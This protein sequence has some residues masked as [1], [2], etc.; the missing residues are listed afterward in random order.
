[1]EFMKITKR[2]KKLLIVVGILLIISGIYYFIYSPALRKVEDTFAQ[3]DGE[4]QRL[5]EL[6]A[7]YE[8]NKSLS[9]EIALIEG[10][11]DDALKSLPKVSDEPLLVKHLHHLF[12]PVGGLN[13]IHID[14]P[15]SRGE[16]SGVGVRLSYNLSYEEFHT[17]LTALER[18]PYKNRID[19]FSIHGGQ[20]ENANVTRE[21]A[22]DMSLTF[23][24]AN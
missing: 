3:I 15:V 17:V 6:V 1:M 9:E 8:S 24:F 22:V 11:I 4:Q 2:E 7:M 18:S 5:T 13:S 19:T 14:D 20:G 16:F 12:L 10:E 23:Y 21:V